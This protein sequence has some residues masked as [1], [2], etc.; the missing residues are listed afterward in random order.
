MSQYIA[1][2]FL[3]MLVVLFVV[4]LTTFL[5]MHAVPGGPFDREKPLPQA[6]LDSLNEKYGL[7]QPVMV[8]YANYMS[9]ILVPQITED[10]RKFDRQY[11][12]S[13]PLGED[14]VL[15]WG[16]F[17][18]SFKFKNQT[19]S[20]IFKQNFPVSIRLG[21]YA[22]VVAMAIGIPA[23]IIAA[24]R[25]NTW[26]DYASMGVALVGVSVPVIISGPILRY[27]FGVQL[28]WVEPAPLGGD[29]EFR[30]FVLPAFALGFAQ[31]A[32]LARLTRAS[33]LQVLNEDYI[34]TARAKGLAERAVIFLHAMKNAMIPV[35]TVL[36]PIFAFLIT[37]S[38]VTEIIF[39]INGLGVFFVRSIQ[40]RDYLVI[41]GTT[42][43][44]AA[45]I[46]LANA[47][48]DIVY[49]WLDPRIQFD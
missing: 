48:V 45:L 18:P 2:R 20:D 8:Q 3:Q 9:G 42:L 25:R 4:S 39:G 13:I 37:G 29:Y 35:V 1:R 11:F 19:V 17:G 33:L 7:D 16:N 21:L 22:M 26:W 6:T 23:G 24:V 5:L 32:L 49:A 27:V 41:M 31:S 36:G 14:Q 47:M 15:R 40:N 34:R 46:V 28:G 12:L 38:F 10:K 43:L 30:H 44:F